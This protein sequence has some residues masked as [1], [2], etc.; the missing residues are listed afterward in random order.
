MGII[1]P[2]K[3]GFAVATQSLNLVFALFGFGVIWNLINLTM[4]TRLG[5]T[6]A[7]ATPATP[8][9]SGAMIGIGL[10]FILL[11]FFVQ[12]GSLGFVCDKLKTGK[13]SLATFFSTGTKFYVRLLILGLLVA[14]IVGAFILLAGLVIALLAGTLSIL[15][16]IVAVVIAAIGIYF[17]VLMFLAPYFI[18]ASDQKVIAS[19]K[20]SVALVRKNI[21]TVLGIAL[22]LIVV[23]FLIGI[24]LGVIFALL[25]AAVKGMA[26][27]IV[28]AVLSSFVNAFLGV[29]V[30]GSF[31]HFFFEASSNNTSGAK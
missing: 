3:K 10:I 17:V 21:L 27:Q 8:A 23:G 12:A 6:E 20:Q 1:E 25:S 13:A 16:I 14:A 29:L 31:M 4:T 7:G 24:V 11:S 30:T 18:V 2:V 15:G 28:F 5:A 22:I 26:S 9:A 19:V